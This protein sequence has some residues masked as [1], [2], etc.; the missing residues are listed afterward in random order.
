[1]FIPSTP[2]PSFGS[3]SAVCDERRPTFTRPTAKL[4]ELN[5]A[6]HRQHKRREAASKKP[7]EWAGGGLRMVLERVK[8]QAAR[9]SSGTRLSENGAS[10]MAPVALS[11]E[12]ICRLRP[13]D[14]EDSEANGDFAG[15]TEEGR[16]EALDASTVALGGNNLPFDKVIGAGASQVIR[17]PV[18]C[19]SVPG[20]AVRKRGRGRGR[21]KGGRRSSRM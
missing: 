13:H 15:A 19:C 7:R 3:V 10:S 6:R 2:L 11:A 20:D 8:P 14:E 4:I 17:N 21:W 9:S 16:I 18:S 5:R 1:M 12:V